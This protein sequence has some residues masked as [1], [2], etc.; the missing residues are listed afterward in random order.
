MK[1]KYFASVQKSDGK[2]KVKISEKEIDQ[3]TFEVLKEIDPAVVFK[4][5]FNDVNQIQSMD[6]SDL[7]TAMGF[8]NR[9]ITNDKEP[10]TDAE[11]KAKAQGFRTADRF[12]K[13]LTPEQTKM[14]KSLFGHLDASGKPLFTSLVLSPTKQKWD[15]KLNKF[16]EQEEISIATF[17][18][19]DNSKTASSEDKTSKDTNRYE[20]Y[21]SVTR[22]KMNP[23]L[24]SRNIKIESEF[25]KYT[26]FLKSQN[27]K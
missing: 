1:T 9:M 8:F 17:K 21:N 5:E 7:D 2:N 18:D 24:T 20:Y 11:I 19:K 26:E 13:S 27:K 6:Y 25:S 22:A 3:K 23:V 10:K 14:F 12:I 15:S 4:V 16:V